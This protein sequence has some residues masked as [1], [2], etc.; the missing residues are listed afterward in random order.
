MIHRGRCSEFNIIDQLIRTALRMS[1]HY[2][3]DSFVSLE[4]GKQGYKRC[5]DCQIVHQNGGMI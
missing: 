3:I 4:I 1:K 5:T 2:N